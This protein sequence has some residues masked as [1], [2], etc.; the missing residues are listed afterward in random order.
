MDWY[1]ADEYDRQHPTTEEALPGLVASGLVKPL[2]LL[3]NESLT[4]WTPAIQLRPQLFGTSAVPPV[5]TLQQRREISVAGQ[6]V[7]SQPAPTDSMAVC[8]LVF[9]LIGLFCFPLV[10]IGGVI[11]GHIARK[12]ASESPIPTSSGGIALAGLICGYLSLVVL[13]LIVVFYGIAIFAA[14]ADGGANGTP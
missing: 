9:G 3:W 1:Y 6:G 4:N 2:T 10:G 14:I 8:A 5:L 12:R 7:G 13:L 11:C